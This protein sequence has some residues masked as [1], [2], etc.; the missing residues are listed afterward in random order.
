MKEGGK[1]KVVNDGSSAL[2]LCKG[3]GATLKSYVQGARLESET[4]LGW[5][6]EC[7]LIPSVGAELLR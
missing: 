1:E 3:M 6:V 5:N 2:S 4:D 7:G